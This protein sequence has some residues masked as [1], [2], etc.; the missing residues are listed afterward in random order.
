M[1][2]GAG[3]P[4]LGAGGPRGWAERV[5]VPC[6]TPCLPDVRILHPES[7]VRVPNAARCLEGTRYEISLV[8]NQ[9]PKA[10]GG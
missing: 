8:E 3:F 7:P 6:A 1:P 10:L 9:G 5:G 4:S 2:R